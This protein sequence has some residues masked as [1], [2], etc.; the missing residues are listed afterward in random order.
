MA[1]TPTDT[2][3][4][5]LSTTAGNITTVDAAKTQ[6]VIKCSFFNA[7]TVART[8]TV[9]Y[10]RKSE[11]TADPGARLAQKKIPPGKSWICYEAI[12]QVIQISASLQASADAAN[13]VHYNVSTDVIS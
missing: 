7:D 3:H 12:P 10:L 9:Y 4:G 13:V 2:G 1:I 8:V 5:L 11:T 6:R